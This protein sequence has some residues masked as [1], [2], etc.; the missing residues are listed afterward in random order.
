MK[1]E[2]K[3]FGRLSAKCEIRSVCRT[4]SDRRFFGDL[5]ADD[6]EVF[7]IKPDESSGKFNWFTLCCEAANI[8][9]NV[10]QNTI[11]AACC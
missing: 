8:I 7:V 1:L 9:T 10:K 4:E 11:T 6:W 3:M 2:E 5:F